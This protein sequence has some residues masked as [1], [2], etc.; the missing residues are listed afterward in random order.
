MAS[1]LGYNRKRQDRTEETYL[2]CLPGVETQGRG[3]RRTMKGC[4]QFWIAVILHPIAAVLAWINIVGRS[5]LG[6]MQ[7]VLWIIVSTI[8]FGPILYVT[9]GGGNLW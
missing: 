8:W 7:K 9:V 4:F 5:D 6:F 3:K 1:T 2:A